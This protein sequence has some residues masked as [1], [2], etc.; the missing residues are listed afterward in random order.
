MELIV[1]TSR[2]P[3]P[4]LVTKAR[5]RARRLEAPLRPAESQGLRY[6]VRRDGEDICFPDGRRLFPHPG[7]FTAKM[8]VGRQHPLLRAINPL[9]RAQIRVLDATAGLGQD[10]LHL[11]AW[12]HHVLAVERVPAL[13][14]LLKAFL[15]RARG[16]KRPWSEAAGRVRAVTG[17]AADVL[18]WTPP[19]T[20][21]AVF[22]DPMFSAPRSAA[23]DYDLFRAWADPRPL[24]VALVRR[25]T[26]QSAA[27]TV[28]KVPAGTLPELQGALAEAG[29]NRR[30]TSR[31][32]DYWVVEKALAEPEWA[33]L[34]LRRRRDPAPVAP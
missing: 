10:A 30:V 1:T 12:G 23:P 32:F 5:S 33:S 4:A 25:A 27:R 7:L 11:A 18:S 20:F 21:D 31:A 29:F 19:E 9:G 8:Q 2:H 14:C 13:S 24:S 17:N 16:Q 26:L 3:P 6:R 15:A 22:L 34:K 28:F